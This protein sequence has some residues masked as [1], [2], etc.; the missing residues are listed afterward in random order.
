[1]EKSFGEYR[2]EEQAQAL[3][4]AGAAARRQPW[5]APTWRHLRLRKSQSGQD[6]NPDLANFSS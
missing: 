4:V 6:T 2:G 1:M 5:N 3:P